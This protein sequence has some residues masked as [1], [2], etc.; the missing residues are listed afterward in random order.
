MKIKPLQGS[1]KRNLLFTAAFLC[2]TFLPDLIAA[3]CN[4]IPIRF[5]GVFFLGIALFGFLLSL[6]N[7]WLSLFFLILIFIMQAVELCFTVYFGDSIKPEDLMNIFRESQDVFD[8]TYLKQVWWIPLVL[9]T[10][11]A[12]CLKFSKNAVKVPFVWILVFYLAAHKPYRAYTQTKGIWY[13]QPA[14]TRPT[15]KN[16]ISTFAYFTFQY[17]P[18]GYAQKNVTYEPYALTDTA[19]DTDNVLLIFGESL[20]GGHLP[21]F[22]YE[23]QTMPNLSRRFEQDPN[24]HK[25]LAESG[26]ISTATSTLLFFNTVREP[27][28]AKQLKNGV[29]NLFTA[30]K[31]KGFNTYYFSNQESR[32]TM[33]LHAAAID[34][35]ETHDSNSIL[36]TRYRDEGL[37]HLL[38]ELDL[39]KGK[40]FVVLHMRSPHSPYENRYKGR[41][42]EFEKFTPAATATDRFEYTTNTYDNALLYTDMIIDQLVETFEKMSKGRR[43]SVFITADHGQLFNYQGHWW[44]HNNLVLEQGKVP[45]F[46]KSH[47]SIDLPNR[48]VSHYEIGKLILK[49]FGYELHNPNESDAPEFYLH[50]NNID[51]PYDFLAYT[52]NP[53]GGVPEVLYQKNTSE[54]R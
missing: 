37:T 46:V 31:S 25:S 44:G 47:H 8:P 28:N 24:W 42:D 38:S 43:N 40:N 35:V 26:G 52:F 30:A 21:M 12:L 9:A 45:F 4:H 34:R 48:T 6:T 22:G 13:F 51:Y 3:F 50:G 1:L 7:R 14:L 54:L 2:L 33:G 53:E 49:D 36:F 17:Y 23:R 18:Q 27:A 11:F 29:S 10:S 5:E 39:S 41:E 20:Y 32:L 19:S 16:S 15:L